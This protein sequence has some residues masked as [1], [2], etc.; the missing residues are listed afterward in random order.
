MTQ[1][2]V[3]PEVRQ[4]GKRPFGL[5]AI[6]VLLLLTIFAAALDILRLRSGLATPLL[7]QL[8]DIVSESASLSTLPP[9]VFSDRNLLLL[10]NVV[11]ILV[12][13]L[14]VIGLWFR[15]WGAW[16]MAM[17]LIGLGLGYNIWKYLEGAPFYLSMFIHVVSVFYMNERSVR[18][19]FERPTPT[20]PPSGTMWS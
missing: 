14:T 7:L 11:I 6:M 1:P 10:S 8:A 5:Y 17:L 18:Q 12:I 16:I 3:N 15:L 4:A 19:V 20:A 13:L 2:V 9:L